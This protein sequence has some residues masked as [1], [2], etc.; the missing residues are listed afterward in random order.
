[1]SAG[2]G[3]SRT[4]SD[5]GPG[6]SVRVAVGGASVPGRVVAW[7]G[8]GRWRVEVAGVG[9]DVDAAGL[10]RAGGGGL[11]GAVR[12]AVLGA[13]RGE[14]QARAVRGLDSWATGG[15][16]G[17]VA[18][19]NYLARLEAALPAPWWAVLDYPPGLAVGHPDR[20]L[21]LYLADGLGNT[22]DAAAELSRTA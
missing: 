10:S 16:T 15:G 19:R 6:D 3:L 12:A 11:P 13:A 4:A 21:R 17:A 7:L 9:V 14:H 8:A 1:V 20:K 2:G 22:I 18:R 5:F